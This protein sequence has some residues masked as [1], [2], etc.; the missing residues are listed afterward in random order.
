MTV[1][2]AD[3]VG[4][5]ANER[6]RHFRVDDGKANMARP[7][8]L[9]VWRKLES[10][11]LGN[12]GFGLAGDNVQVAV[13]WKLPG[14][15]DKVTEQH[16]CEVQRQMGDGEFATVPQ[17]ETWLGWLVG[18]VTGLETQSKGGRAH[19][20]QVIEVWVK[21]GVI[22]ETEAWNAKSRRMQA[23]Y[24]CGSRDRGGAQS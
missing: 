19:V 16:L 1:E 6:T 20:R 21:A 13:P 22:V 3:S 14:I 7:P 17:A 10:V 24:R 8:E 4:I 12:G 9:A 18:R 23:V 11:D 15:F 2:E 5:S